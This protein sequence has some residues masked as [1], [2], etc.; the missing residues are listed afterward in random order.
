ISARAR[1]SL[2]RR[3]STQPPRRARCS[4]FRARTAIPPRSAL[5]PRRRSKQSRSTSAR[6]RR[7]YG[8]ARRRPGSAIRSPAPIA[9]LPP[10]PRPTGTAYECAGSR[11]E[12]GVRTIQINGVPSQQSEGGDAWFTNIANAFRNPPAKYILDQRTGYGG[13]IDAVDH[14]AG[15]M[16]AR[17]EFG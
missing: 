15:F 8:P 2:R 7:A 14:L 5:A 12:N 16:V 1:S 3:C 4:N 9:S 13:G 10:S 11:D 6:S 17:E